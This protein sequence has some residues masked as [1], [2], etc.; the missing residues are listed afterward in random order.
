MKNIYKVLLFLFVSLVV[1]SACED[2]EVSNETPYIKY[3]RPTEAAQSDS[4]LVAA[5]MGSTIAIVGE[6]LGS[7]ISIHFNDVKAKLNPVYVTDETILVTVPGSI[8]E[9]I[10]NTITLTTSSGNQLIY[11][12]QT[13]IPS[14]Q[15]ASINCEWAPEGSVAVLT[16]SYFFAKEDGSIDVSFPGGIDGDVVEFSEEELKVVVPAGVLQGAISVENDFGVGRSNFIYKDDTGIFIDAENPTLWNNWGLSDFASENGVDGSYIKFEGTTGSWVWP[17]N[18]IQL[19][20]VNPSGTPLVSDGEVDDYALK[21]ECYV[22]EWHDTP[23]LVWFDNDGGHDVD[24]DF[25]QYHWTPYLKG[26]V[27]SNYTTDGWITVIMPLSDFVY[28]KDES[29]DSRKIASF[30]ELVNLNMMW[31]GKVDEATSEF[32]LKVWMDNIRLVKIN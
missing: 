16:G 10:S 18:A 22:H 7:V 19:F 23:L 21:F 27:T 6:D 4:L 14:P 3:V 2:D 5:S 30:D 9:E 15:I 11:N 1:F 31:F 29:E 28:S 32:G 17:A 8:P 12:F 20:Y 26:E 24:S 25:A 13:I